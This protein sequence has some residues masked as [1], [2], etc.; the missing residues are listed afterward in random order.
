MISDR[1]F[2]EFLERRDFTDFGV[3]Y[4]RTSTSDE[5]DLYI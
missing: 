1:A 4:A 5:V 3:D 2:T